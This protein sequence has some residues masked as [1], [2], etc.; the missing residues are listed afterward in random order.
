ML[1]ISERIDTES[2]VFGKNIKYYYVAF[3]QIYQSQTPA[4]ELF[5]SRPANDWIGVWSPDLSLGIHEQNSM[6]LRD[7]F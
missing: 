5:L 2:I 7:L 3:D 1:V 4:S 6:I